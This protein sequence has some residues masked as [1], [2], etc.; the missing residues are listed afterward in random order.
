MKQSEKEV[1]V[2]EVRQ[3]MDRSAIVVATH[4]RGLTV[5]QMGVLRKQ[6]H[7]NGC[8]YRV[9]KNTLAKRAAAG[10]AF[11]NLSGLLSGPTGLAFSTDPVAPAKVLAGFVKE[12][13]TLEIRG[14]VMNGR[15]LDDQNVAKLATMPSREVM[16]A[17]LLGTLNGPIQNFVGVLAAVPAGLVRVLDQIR[18]SKETAAQA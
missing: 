12:N 10:T 15:V 1:I 7:D 18:K 3:L 13:P 17:R 11:E 6:M 8:Q 2:N 16:L 5:T 4:Y 14:A 9:V